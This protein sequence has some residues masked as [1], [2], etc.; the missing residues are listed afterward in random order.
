MEEL[1]YLDNY[2]YVVQVCIKSLYYKCVL[3]K[4][5]IS[6]SINVSHDLYPLIPLNVTNVTSIYLDFVDEVSRFT[7]VA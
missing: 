5:Y 1:R 4:Y 6:I 2:R 7:L 3:N